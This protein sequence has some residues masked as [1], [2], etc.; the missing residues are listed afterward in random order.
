M[1]RSLARRAHTLKV[2][3]ILAIA[4][5]VVL[6]FKLL[7]HTDSPYQL[8]AFISY[9]VCCENL[10]KKIKIFWLNVSGK[11]FPEV[12]LKCFFEINWNILKE[13]LIRRS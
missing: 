6:L 13:V 4:R 5:K 9:N 11:N 2:R 3:C 1:L 7:R 12:F 10:T 8:L